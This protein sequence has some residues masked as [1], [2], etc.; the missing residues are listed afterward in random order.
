MKSFIRLQDFSG[1]TAVCTIITPTHIICANVGDSRCVIGSEG[2]TIAMTEDHKPSNPQEKER[3]ESAGGFVLMDRVNGELAMSR[4]L[5][6]FRYKQQPIPDVDDPDKEL[7]VLDDSSYM[8][9]CY[10]DISVYERK[11]DKDEVL[12]LACDGVWDEV[13]N[14]EAVQ[15]L[16]E[17]VFDID[18][19]DEQEALAD[20]KTAAAVA[21][22]T[23]GAT[24][25]SPIS[26]KDAAASLIDL[27]LS[28]GSTDNISAIVVKFPALLSTK[29][30]KS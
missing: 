30:I 25:Q 5:G 8:V 29:E 23:N 17:I 27:A 11:A 3:I 18:P 2:K 22:R 6:D 13:G 14:E 16:V 9:I 20:Q 1:C 7:P 10:P 21:T 19:F 28:C 26:A 15:Y 24:A 12:I 4:A